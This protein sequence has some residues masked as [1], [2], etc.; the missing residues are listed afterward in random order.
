MSRT[1]NEAGTGIEKLVGVPLQRHTSMRATVLI[2]MHLTGVP[3]RQQL[4]AIP[5][6]PSALSLIEVVPFTQVFQPSLLRA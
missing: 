1:F 6:E 5:V 4:Q 3:D 2:H